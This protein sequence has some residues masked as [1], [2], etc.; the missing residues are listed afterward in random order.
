MVCAGGKKDSEL[1]LAMG[2]GGDL[3]SAR[4]ALEM[5]WDSWITEA[6]FAY[7]QKIGRFLP[8]PVSRLPVL[9]REREIEQEREREREGERG[10][11]RE[12]EGERGRERERKGERG[13]D[14]ERQRETEGERETERERDSAADLTALPACSTLPRVSDSSGINTVRLPIG[15]WSL[16][17][18]YMAGT[19]FEPVSS[20][21]TNSW[22]RVVRAVNWA[23]KYGLG[24]LVD[25][26]GG[27]SSSL[28]FFPNRY[29][30][31]SQSRVSESD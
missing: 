13:R 29:R 4:M 9:L 6:D 20:V 31:R 23:A 28:C 7:L 3:E 30:S 5:H 22:P 21:Y 17:P 16:G 18:V 24:V 11:E 14:R 1:D 19:P 26:H 10:R 25:L 2:Y 12:R 27:E 15:Y 8:A